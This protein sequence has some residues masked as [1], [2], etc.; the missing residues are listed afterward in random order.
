MKAIIITALITFLLTGSIQAQK[1]LQDVVYLKN[2]SILRGKIIDSITDQKIKLL[3]ADGSQ[4]VFTINEIEKI[5]REKPVVAYDKRSGNL[6]PVRD[7]PPDKEFTEG[8]TA[9]LEFGNGL[10]AGRVSPGIMRMKIN[11]IHGYR[12]NPYLAVAGGTGLNVYPGSDDPLLIPLYADLRVYALRKRTTPYFGLALGYFF[13]VFG[14]ESS[15]RGTGLLCNPCLG[16]CTR[17]RGK[18]SVYI[19]LEYELKS[20]EW[21]TY[22]SYDYRQYTTE[23]VYGQSIRF[24]FGFT[25]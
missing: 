24:N 16:V 1:N 3:M 19:G 9:R 25:F 18:K 21:Y 15:F 22:Y 10:T 20:E 2:G 23:T 17:T 8:Y 4:L 13:K 11:F 6:V 7:T 14:D 12:I 5:A